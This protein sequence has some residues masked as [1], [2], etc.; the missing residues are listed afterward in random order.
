MVD[1]YAFGKNNVEFF[2]ELNFVFDNEKYK[3]DKPHNLE[4]LIMS[5]YMQIF[6]YS[7]DDRR[8]SE[9]KYED[10]YDI[11]KKVWLSEDAKKSNSEVGK[12]YMLGQESEEFQAKTKEEKTEYILEEIRNST[13]HGDFIINNDGTITMFNHDKD[14]NITFKMTFEFECIVD[15]CEIISKNEKFDNV[16]P[17]LLK[18]LS[19]IKGLDKQIKNNCENENNYSVMSQISHDLKY[20]I[21]LFHLLPINEDDFHNNKIY[22]DSLLELMPSREEFRKG[23]LD[24]T[25]NDFNV[26]DLSRMRNSIAHNEYYIQDGYLHLYDSWDKK[27]RIISLNCSEIE[28]RIQIITNKDF[29]DL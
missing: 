5:I 3:G 4:N 29:R 7:F 2:N 24:N 20:P 8:P 25:R 1:F 23:E 6:S 18:V 11:T 27:K 12:I 10:I 22:I 16:S 19:Y 14:G 13:V 15:I 26:A 9:L 17:D 28:E 21:L